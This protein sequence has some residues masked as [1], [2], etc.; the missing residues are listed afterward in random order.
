MW[1]GGVFVFGRALV[2]GESAIWRVGGKRPRDQVENKTNTF[3]LNDT[4]RLR[5]SLLVRFVCSALVVRNS[6]GPT[7]TGRNVILT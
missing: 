7:E 1:Q 5:A 4:L 6:R 2:G 3:P